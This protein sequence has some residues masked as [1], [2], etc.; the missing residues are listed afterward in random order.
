LRI[1]R[2][3]G[4]QEGSD[5]Q[6]NPLTQDKVNTIILIGLFVSGSVFVKG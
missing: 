6:Y 4:L 5:A 2:E 3:Q 1:Q